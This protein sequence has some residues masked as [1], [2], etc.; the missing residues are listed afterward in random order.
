MAGKRNEDILLVISTLKVA[1]ENHCIFDY[2]PPAGFEN[3][4]RNKIGGWHKSIYCLCVCDAS[5]PLCR[6]DAVYKGVFCGR[7]CHRIASR[8]SNS[9]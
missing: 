1:L 3:L 5:V 6:C 7:Q 8:C 4:P 9:V 2:V